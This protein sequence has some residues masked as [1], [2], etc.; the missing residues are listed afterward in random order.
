[1][2]KTEDFTDFGASLLDWFDD[3]QLKVCIQIRV[4]G[5]F[6]EYSSTSVV[7]PIETDILKKAVSGERIV[8]MGQI[9]LFNEPHISIMVKNMPIED[10]ERC[11][12]LRDHLAIII[13][14]SESIIKT[15]QLKI[16]EKKE[17]DEIINSGLDEFKQ[18]IVHVNEE[19][20]KYINTSKQQYKSLTERVYADLLN[21]NLSDQQHDQLVQLLGDYNQSNE[22]FDELN[23]N[24]E[25]KIS[26][27]EQKIRIA[28]P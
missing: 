23:I 9:Y 15:I 3:F 25:S 1:M 24:L 18:Q 27:L 22:E 2:V 13:H 10:D 8:T 17:S 11:G 28:L 12:R 21:L 19:I 26:M 7:R 5:E 14:S 6:F 20:F 4:D 16:N